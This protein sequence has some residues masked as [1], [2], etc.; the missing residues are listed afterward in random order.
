M[1]VRYLAL[2]FR[3]A[4]RSKDSYFS[5]APIKMALSILSITMI[6]RVVDLGGYGYGVSALFFLNI[7]AALAAGYL[8]PYFSGLS[9]R[10][11]DFLIKVFVVTGFL[12]LYSQVRGDLTIVLLSGLALLYTLNMFIYIMYVDIGGAGFRDKWNALS[13]LESIGGFYWL[14]GIGLGL[15]ISFVLGYEWNYFVVS[16][17]LLAFLF[18]KKS[19]NAP[20]RGAVVNVSRA[21]RNRHRYLLMEV[22]MV[23]FG[24]SI[25]YTQLIPYLSGLGAFDWEIYGLSLLASFVSLLTYSYVGDT[26]RGVDSLFKGVYYRILTYGLLLGVILLSGSY[27][28][29]FSPI[30]FIL[31]GFSWGYISISLGSYILMY[32]SKELSRLYLASGLGGG[33]GA[34]MSGWV[35]SM[36]S[37]YVTLVISIGVLLV[38]GLILRRI[39]IYPTR[40]VLVY[41]IH[42]VEHTHHRA[43]VRARS[44]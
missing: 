5:I 44:R 10:W 13:R 18:M 25:A 34:I 1:N 21:R 4:L 32:R 19:F 42:V 30:V 39:R 40:D 33:L 6:V 35:V 20:S 14:L 12:S 3:Y 27:I 23:N 11:R 41:R 8:S 37:Y 24:L 26:F 43:V 38:S 36:Y 28:L 22:F 15:F 29:L 31:M 7:F 2:P 9:I 16:L 17:L